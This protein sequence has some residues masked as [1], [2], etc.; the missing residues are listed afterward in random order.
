MVGRFAPL[1]LFGPAAAWLVVA[2]SASVMSVADSQA[3][4]PVARRFGDGVGDAACRRCHPAEHAS[5]HASYHRTMTQRIDDP[6]VTLLAPFAGETLTALGFVATMDRAPDGRPHMRIVDAHGSAIIDAPIELAV[7]SHRAQQYVARIDRGG[8][9]GELW[10]LPVAWHVGTER[11]IHLNGAFLSPDGRD[12]D[13]DDY[14]RHFSRY[15]DNCLLCHNTEPVPGQGLDGRFDSHATQWG[16]GCEACHGPGAEHVA[17]MDAPIR[18]VLSTLG[19]DGTMVDPRTL[20]VDRSSEICGRCHGQRIARDIADVL[21]HGDGFVP[22]D[23]LADT[24]RPITKD[25]TVAGAPELGFSSRFWPD[26]TPRLSAYEYQGLI[27]SACFAEGRGLGCGGCHSMHGNEPAM[28]LRSDF[29]PV[30]SCVRCHGGATLSGGPEHGGHGDRVACVDCHMPQTTYGLL[31]GMLSHRITS[32]DPAAWLGRHDGPDACTQCHVERSRGW[33]AAAMTELGFKPRAPAA[34]DPSETWASRV[35]LD[36]HGGDPIQRA[37]AAHAL[38]WPRAV[39]DRKTRM[40][41]LGAAALDEYPAVRLF[42]LRGLAQLATAEGRQDV[43]AL[44]EGRV[45]EEPIE[46]R[47]ELERAL[48]SLLGPG[49]LAGQPERISALEERRDQTEIW[50][51]E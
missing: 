3:W 6:E 48:A 14:L 11:W 26:G 15:N 29:D 13:R 46:A 25:A 2:T 39:G 40:A 51:G 27:G 43:L 49:P 7:G 9:P 12:G 31:E 37:L 38:A 22:G 1:V 10:R 23:R 30:T 24:S 50:I 45:P 17:R 20:S 16:I 32:P 36:L 35:V 5:W 21:A 47:I 19:A 33:A 18:R 41:A 28:Q 42:A 4:G 8:G 44:I 34:E